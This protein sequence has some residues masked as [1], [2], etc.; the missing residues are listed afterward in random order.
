VTANGYEGITQLDSNIDTNSL[1]QLSVQTPV[2]PNAGA[3]CVTSIA[4]GGF[5]IKNYWGNDSSV[6][7]YTITNPAG[8]GAV[9][10]VTATGFI[11]V[12]QLDDTVTPTSTILLTVV[13]PSGVNAGAAIVTDVTTGS[14]TIQ[15]YWGNDT[16]T[17]NYLV[18]N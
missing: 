15:N 4:T 9:G 7:N 17:Y 3:A 8:S 1:L 2:G 10:F 12:T 6:Y 11:P 18:I 14:F 5:Y 16:S 13:I